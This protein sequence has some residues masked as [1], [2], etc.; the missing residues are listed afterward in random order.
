MFCLIDANNFYATCEEIFQPK[1]R[2]K[3]LVVLSN[4]DG[5]VIARSKQAKMLGVKMGEPAFLLKDKKNVVMLSSNFSLYAD[6]SHRMMQTIETFEYPL[7]VYSI[8]ESFLECD[9]ALSAKELLQLGFFIKKKVKKWTG[10][11]VSIGIAKTMTLAKLANREA[12]KKDG[13]SFLDDKHQIEEM[14]KKT[15]LQDIWGIGTR[16]SLRLKKN[17]IY[18][19]K[20]LILQDEIFLKKVLG[21]NGLKTALELKKIPSIQLEE[22]GQKKQSIACCK[23]FYHKKSSLCEI[24]KTLSSYAQIVTE[25]MRKQGLYAQAICVILSTSPFEKPF[26][27]NNI[28]LSLPL[29]SNYTPDFISLAKWGLQKIF[30]QGVLYKKCGIILLDL[31]KASSIQPSLL[32]TE[33]KQNTELMQAVDRIN[34]K[35]DKQAIYFAA[36]EKWEHKPY[37]NKSPRYTT[38]WSDLPTISS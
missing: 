22:F 15:P 20:D 35:F 28:T 21:I 14:L 13:V 4:N 18:S 8:D 33:K 29:A 30:K 2:Y 6:L 16:L 7:Q 32:F 12:K 5:C 31:Q 11:D 10:I 27:S 37:K 17:G 9:E 24:E 36:Q 1:L 3:P 34:Q 23:S 19:G 38:S 25:K 26:Y